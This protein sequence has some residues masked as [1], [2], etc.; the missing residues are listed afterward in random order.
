MSKISEWWSKVGVL[1]IWGD[2]GLLQWH[3]A[4]P[5]PPPPPPWHVVAHY[6]P[7]GIQWHPRNIKTG[8]FQVLWLYWSIISEVINNQF[9]CYIGEEYIGEEGGGGGRLY[10]WGCCCDQLSM[11]GCIH[12]IHIL[13]WIVLIYWTGN[14]KV[15]CNLLLAINWWRAYNSW[16]YD[17]YMTSATSQIIWFMGDLSITQVIYNV[18]NKLIN[19]S[20]CRISILQSLYK[21]ANDT[22]SKHYDPSPYMLND[23]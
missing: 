4:G 17:K 7:G 13:G 10:Q 22:S 19:M 2:N 8:L 23:P 21:S 9:V 3:G 15:N 5:S 1:I 14:F 11:I 20:W 16:K 6:E 18:L 12:I